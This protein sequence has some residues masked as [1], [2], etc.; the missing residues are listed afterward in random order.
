VN[1]AGI[2][3]ERAVIGLAMAS[4]NA[5][6]DLDITP[7]DFADIR[8][9]ALFRL[10]QTRD[11]RGEAT[12]TKAIG[13]AYKQIPA[14]ERAGIDLLYI[15]DCQREAPVTALAEKYGRLLS[16]QAARRRLSEAFKRG[17]QLLEGEV[18]AA[19]VAEIM[20]GEIDAANKDTAQAVPIGH[21]IDD[22]IDSFEN[23]AKAH[24]TPWPELNK[25][26]VGWGEGRLYVVGARPGVGKSILG[27]Q[28][29][30]GLADHGW[31][32][33][34]S[35][36]MSKEEVTT[37]GIAQIG[38]VPLG[39]LMGTSDVTEPLSPRDWQRISKARG[40]FND[41][42]L[43][44]DDRGAVTLTDIRTHA[45][46]LARKPQG[47]SA[48]IVDYLQ[49]MS[50]PRGERKQRHEIVGEF[51]R[52]LKLLAKELGVPVIALTQLNR[53]STQE[54]RRPT[55]ADIRESGAIEQD[56]DVILLLHTETDVATDLDLL[57][58]KN[59]HGTLGPVQLTK[60]GEFARLEPRTWTPHFAPP[61]PA[62]IDNN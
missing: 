3:L 29:A 60:V 36:E 51:S 48:V 23:P 37:R 52:G 62:Y 12:D 13:V 30:I 6:H 45:R 11:K 38:S 54:N 55:M 22:V 8:H 26:I 39:R 25:K 18:T 19:E 43:S 4:R 7:A 44:I 14:D 24:A 58:A 35:L 56:S 28:A 53:A 5:L 34:H 50:A 33:F 57:V 9:A 10:I 27:V 20:R 49:L 31:V 16:D 32:A 21:I 40:E 47:L 1:P 2:D 59:R 42:P 41:M 15:A 61:P 17:A 46:A